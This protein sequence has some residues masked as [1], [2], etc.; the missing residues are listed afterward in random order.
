MTALMMA[1]LCM[2]SCCRITLTGLKQAQ[3]D[4]KPVHNTGHQTP[5][6]ACSMSLSGEVRD[7]IYPRRLD[8]APQSQL[9]YLPEHLYVDME[10][11][12]SQVDKSHLSNY[13]P[14]KN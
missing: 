4:S 1:F 13:S 14:H 2:V 10:S 3:R 7:E 5:S 9:N 8:N 11:L 12:P 6:V